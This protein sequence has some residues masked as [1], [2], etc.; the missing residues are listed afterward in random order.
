M[1]PAGQLRL[2]AHTRARPLSIG[3]PLKHRMPSSVLEGSICRDHSQTSRGASLSGFG[4]FSL[5]QRGQAGRREEGPDPA[6]SKPGTRR[7]AFLKTG[8]P[9]RLSL[10]PEVLGTRS[11]S[12]NGRRRERGAGGAVQAWTRALSTGAACRPELRRVCL[13]SA[14]GAA[15]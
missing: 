1:L 15:A 9:S 8:T 2:D 6:V 12:G 10:P 11:D 3:R 13:R 7:L 14:G 5:K 4:D